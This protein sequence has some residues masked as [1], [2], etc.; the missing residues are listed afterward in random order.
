MPA[1]QVWLQLLRMLS[2][3]LLPDSAA[4][5]EALV[6]FSSERVVDAQIVRSPGDARGVRLACIDWHC[7]TGLRQADICA[8]VESRRMTG[9]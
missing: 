3:Q 7:C 6:A 8:A 5:A 2:L 4:P 9:K 1:A